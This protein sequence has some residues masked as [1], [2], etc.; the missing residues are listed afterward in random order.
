M[1]A[2]AVGKA[3]LPM[4]SELFAHAPPQRA[5]LMC[6]PQHAADARVALGA[7]IRVLACDH[8]LPTRRNLWAARQVRQFVRDVPARARLVVLL[9]GGAS[10][11]LCLPAPRTTLMDVRALQHALQRRGAD[12]SDLNC[13]RK[14]TELLKG[15]RMVSACAARAIDVLVLSDVLGDP[16]DVI[17]SGPCAPDPT[18]HADALRVLAR[19]DCLRVAPRLVAHLRAGAAGRLPDT[20]KRS[21]DIARRCVRHHVLASNRGVVDAVASHLRAAG[22]PVAHVLHAQTGH[23]QVVA[24][25]LLSRL[26]D[27]PLGSAIVLGGEWTV[28]AT[29]TT[30]VGG[31]SQEL[32]LAC[33]EGLASLSPDAWVLALSTD[34]IDGPTDAAGAL[35]SAAHLGMARAQGIDLAQA[36][37][38]HD[39]TQALARLGAL[40][41]TGPTGTNL[42]HVV[43]AYRGGA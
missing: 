20:P 4:A 16:L 15:G 33:V 22:M 18:T 32:A 42:N 2:L 7:G 43:V 27:A 12:I 31:P 11:H 34:G 37:D 24:Q 19:H 26:R 1:W 39:S 6:P 10:A 25:H 41:R 17:A 35:V 8:P 30:G 36:L 13:V 40:L 9:S 14:H 5:L 38:Q 21:S 23:A 29:G 28:H 3:A